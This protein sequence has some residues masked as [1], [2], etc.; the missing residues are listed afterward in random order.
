MNKNAPHR[1]QQLIALRVATDGLTIVERHESDGAFW[2]PDKIARG[3][4]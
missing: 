2:T 4:R 1:I 3:D